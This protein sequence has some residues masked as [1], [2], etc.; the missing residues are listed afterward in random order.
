MNYFVLSHAQARQ[1]AI[2][3]VKTAP[4]GWTV[5]VKPKT[6][7]LDQ[8]AKFHAIC[9]DLAKSRIEWGGKRRTL[10][11]WKVLLVSGHAA[12]TNSGYEIVQGFE[13]EMINLRESTATMTKARS[14]SLI[15]YAEAMLCSLKTP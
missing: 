8:S 15:D 5:Q 1:N 2:E 9:N 14:A 11:E 13:G 7:S 3:A 6:R 12:A 10:E 4:D